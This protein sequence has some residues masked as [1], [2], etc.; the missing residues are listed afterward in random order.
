MEYKNQLRIWNG[1]GLI[2]NQKFIEEK[3]NL[4]EKLKEFL[5]FYFPSKSE[6]SFS[7]KREEILARVTDSKIS[8]FEIE[9]NEILKKILK[10]D[11]QIRLDYSFGQSFPDWI[12]F[13]TGWNL[14]ITDAVAIP[15]SLEEIQTILEFC[16][17]N[18]YR[19]IIY[20]GGTSVVGHIKPELK[21]PTITLSME[22]INRL[23]EIN[24]V[25]SYAIFEAGISGPELEEQLQKF[26]YR[27]GHY[28]QSFELSTLGGWIA[29][30]SSGQQSLYYGRIEDLFLGGKI[31]TNQGILE[32]YPNPA[33]SAGPDL[34]E[35]ILGSEGRI[36][37]LFEAIVKIRP[38]PEVE[39]FH[40]LFFKDS[41]KAIDFIKNVVR[42]RTNLSMI[43]LSFP[44]ETKVN[45]EMAKVMSNQKS[46]EY[47]EKILKFK[48]FHSNY[49]MMIVGFTGTKKEVEF[50][51]KLVFNI[52]KDYGGYVNRIFLSSKLGKSWQKARF[53]TPYLRNL[54]WDIGYGVDTLETCLPWE[55]I[56][57]AK[58][59]IELS[60]KT[61]AQKF[62]EKI[63]VY[64]H[65]SHVYLNGSSLYVT[66]I[67]P[68]KSNP[69]EIFLM[70]KEI[71]ESAS[72]TIVELKG[73]I[74]HQHGVGK[75]HKPYLISEKGK[76]GMDWLE[77]LI[78]HSDP[79]QILN[80]NNLI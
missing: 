48:G 71:K 52:V 51:K 77:T 54:L 68:L 30:R 31:L 11:K 79:D 78:K 32:I 50:S 59:K 3:K 20:G 17:K 21:R 34:K 33:S 72:K 44:E 14:K 13:R 23:K 4:Q 40:G 39:E 55:K 10:I 8:F 70:W 76:I 64:T 80:N 45:L 66:F 42:I 47:L 58:D 61:A 75:D 1:W 29:T 7:I 22:K 9:N 41:I 27:L 43:R 37:I 12:S 26:G 60:I 25:N 73:T 5:N 69:E 65:L 36:G 67:F 56:L 2:E 24:K 6:F 57:E 18:H 19:L 15:K 49:L 38:L 62:N 63:L 74:S 53:T 16:K 46:V 28:P 35:F